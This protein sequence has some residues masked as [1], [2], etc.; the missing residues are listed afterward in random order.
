MRRAFALLAGLLAAA[1]HAPA[2]AQS[3]RCN[4]QL[5][6]IGDSKLSVVRKC[7]EP[8]WR[9]AVCVSRELFLWAQPVV[10]GQVLQP[11]ITP[12]CVPME[13]WTYDRGEGQFLGIVRFRNASVESMRDGERQR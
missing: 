13:E 12:Q 4:G 7:G 6:N 8:A 9:E 5:V 3:L 2:A 11:L 1:M 10:P